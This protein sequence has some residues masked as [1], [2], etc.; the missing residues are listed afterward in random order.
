MTQNTKTYSRPGTWPR[1]KEFVWTETT[2][3]IYD[4]CMKLAAEA[5]KAMSKA[6]KRPW[7]FRNGKPADICYDA[8][9]WT[10]LWDAFSRGYLSE[11]EIKFCTM[12]G[13][14]YDWIL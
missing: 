8:A 7:L 9:R 10:D 13:I 3:A 1:K 4:R 11:E 5:N 2:S 12:N 6:A 14:A